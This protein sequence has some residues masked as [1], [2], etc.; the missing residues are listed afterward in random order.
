MDEVTKGADLLL[1]MDKCRR[2]EHMGLYS[3]KKEEVIGKD[4]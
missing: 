1:V 2:K 3:D 4:S